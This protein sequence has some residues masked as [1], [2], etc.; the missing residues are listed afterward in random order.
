[1]E[2]I[3]DF[4]QNTDEWFQAR[5][6]SIGGSSIQSVCAKGS[7]KSRSTLM[8]RMVGEILSGQKYEGYYNKDME[9]GLELEP[10]ARNAY[11]V[12]TGNEVE[13]V[14]MIR[15]TQHKHE[16]PDGLVYKKGKIEIKCVIP[17]V[18]VETIHK[19]V[20]PSTYRKQIQ[21]GLDI[22][23]REWCDF[24]SYCPVIKQKPI[25][26]H[27]VFRDEKLIKTMHEE[28]DIFIDEMLELVEKIKEI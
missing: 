11:E 13:Q 10:A 19:N 24:I 4:Q 27:K 5:I 25:W 26:I 2:I 14:A 8:Y 22:S 21:W 7:G 3:K 15:A 17:S 1:M 12:V 6:G 20:T 28:A 16:S 18:H 23:E 9:R